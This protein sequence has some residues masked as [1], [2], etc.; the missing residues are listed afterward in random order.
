MEH[1]TDAQEKIAKLAGSFVRGLERNFVEKRVRHRLPLTDGVLYNQISL[2]GIKSTALGMAGAYWAVIG[3]VFFVIGILVEQTV[4]SSVNSLRW[5][6]LAVAGVLF[7]I[8]IIRMS[9]S[10]ASQVNHRSKRK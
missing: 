7:L 1:V 3:F 10:I 4:N 9:Q 2:N 6:V 8:S 5:S